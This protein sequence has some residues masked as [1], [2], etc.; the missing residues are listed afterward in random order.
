MNI[1]TNKC[2]SVVLL[3]LSANLFSGERASFNIAGKAW[4]TEAALCIY[5]SLL[6]LIKNGNV[7]FVR[8][9]LENGAD[10]NGL[11]DDNL[12]AAVIGGHI[13][14]VRLLLQKGANNRSIN[15]AFREAIFNNPANPDSFNIAKLLLENGADINHVD[16][17]GYTPLMEAVRRGDINMVILLLDNGADVN[18]FNGLNN[19]L[20]L[21]RSKPVIFQLLLDRGAEMP[22]AIDIE[23]LLK[24]FEQAGVDMNAKCNLL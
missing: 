21:A 17:C 8:F 4:P 18:H 19:A 13:N 16:V 23:S 3:I 9:L 14:M 15:K 20:S 2:L 11:N 22:V 6:E 5:G 1:K 7:D 12:K 10:V 24:H